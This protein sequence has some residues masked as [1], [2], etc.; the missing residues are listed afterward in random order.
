MTASPLSFPPLTDLTP[1]MA[2]VEFAKARYFLSSRDSAER[3]VA[4]PKLAQRYRRSQIAGCLNDD[5]DIPGRLWEAA[6]ST[7]MVAEHGE[8]T[9]YNVMMSAL[10]AAEDRPADDADKPKVIRATQ[11]VWKD[12]ATLP[13]RERLYGNLLIRKFLSGTIAP[14]GAGKSSL[15]VAEALASVSGRALLGVAPFGKMRVW[16]HNLEDP[17][18]ETER[19]IQAVALRF[20][21]TVDDIGD[22]LFVDSGRDQPL[23]MATATKTGAMI[24]RPVIDSLVAE[25]IERGI[26]IIV[27]DPFVSC[28]EASENDNQAMDMIAKEWAKVADRCNCAVHLVHHTRKGE[29]E[30]STESARGGKALTDACRVVRAV[31]RMTKE[32][33]EKAGVENHRLYFRTIN[34]KANL[35]PPADQSDWFKLDSVDLG[36]GPLNSPGDSIGVVVP[37]QWPN[38]LDGIT[39]ADF[40]K[41]AGCIQ[42]GKWRESSQAKDW[43]GKAIAQALGFDLESRTD[44]AK[45]I[46]LIKVWLAAGSLIVTDG[47]D[48]KR[49]PRKFIEVAETP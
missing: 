44:K 12:A 49:M 2:Q 47:E 26:D 39:G 13:R 27:I 11:Y 46:G 3:L 7:D 19:K 37:W 22:R 9:V 8:E 6:E 20:N 29:A 36:N 48:E 35:A 45:V 18:E 34:D 14:G 24:V 4:L 32:E 33:A 15:I 16:V 31:N 17:Q 21:L 30:V 5:V 23:V 25:A 40:E 10:Q 38:A 43:V 41:A 42:A 1:H 28:H